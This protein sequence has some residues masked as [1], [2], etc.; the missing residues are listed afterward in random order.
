MKEK[1]EVQEED[2]RKRGRSYR[3][4]KRQRSSSLKITVPRMNSYTGNDQ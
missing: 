2:I 3:I 4:Q 1:E